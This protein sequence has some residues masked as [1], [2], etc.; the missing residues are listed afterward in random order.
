[1]ELEQ[2]RRTFHH[3]GIDGSPATNLNI[4]MMLIILL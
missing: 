1:M 2:E 3:N 4:R